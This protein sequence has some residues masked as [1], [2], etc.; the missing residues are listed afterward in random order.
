MPL[1]HETGH[2]TGNR[3]LLDQIA[4][5][6]SIL[7]LSQVCQGP[8]RFNSLKR[9]L[10]GISQKALTQALRRLERNGILEREV[11]SIAPVAVEYR[12][13]PLGRTL[14]EPFASLYRWTARYGQDVEAAQALYDERH[15]SGHTG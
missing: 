5:K 15:P 13:T 6:W 8:L 3:L 7:I 14:E 9:S 10:P 12:V 2:E 1:G 11:K 4:D